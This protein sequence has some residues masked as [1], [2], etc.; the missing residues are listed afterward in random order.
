MNTCVRVIADLICLVFISE[1]NEFAGKKELQTLE[2]KLF[3]FCYAG[4]SIVFGINRIQTVS[5]KVLALLLKHIFDKP[6]FFK[7]IGFVVYKK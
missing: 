7:K 3:F 6:A 2:R 5:V 1:V 4:K